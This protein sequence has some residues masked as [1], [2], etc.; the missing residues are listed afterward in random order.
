MSELWQ[1]LLSLS[2]LTIGWGVIFVSS[3]T[4]FRMPFDLFLLT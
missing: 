2:E 1:D 4:K 3:T